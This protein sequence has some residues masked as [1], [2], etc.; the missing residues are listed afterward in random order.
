M[1]GAVSV[2]T[3]TANDGS[4]RASLE[5]NAEDVE[6]LSPKGETDYSEPASVKNPEGTE[7]GFTAVETDELPFDRGL[8]YP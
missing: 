3:Y 6:F 1:T 5:V 4:T 2:H 7:G 8:V